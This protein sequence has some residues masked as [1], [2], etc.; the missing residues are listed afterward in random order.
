M[1]YLSCGRAAAPA[2]P[3][4]VTSVIQVG[5]DI[6]HFRG[7]VRFR[8]VRRGE[9]RAICL[10]V[11]RLLPFLATFLPPAASSKQPASKKKSPAGIA[12]GGAF[13]AAGR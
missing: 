10:V 11:V 5:I 7:P 8:V 4:N 13:G 2:A 9:A 6:K 12:A 3:G 1:A